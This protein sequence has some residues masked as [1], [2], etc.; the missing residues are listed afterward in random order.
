MS[1]KFHEP[2]LGLRGKDVLRRA[3]VHVPKS[4]SDK[5]SLPL[6]LSF[7]G[8]FGTAEMQMKASEMNDLSDKEE[9]LLVYP[10]GILR[11]WNSFIDTAAAQRTVHDV[12]FIDALLNLLILKF[13]ADPSRIY[14]VG[15]SNGGHIT[16]TLADAIGERLAAI[17][18]VASGIRTGADYR[19]THRLPLMIIHG[20]DDEYIPYNGGKGRRRED[21]YMPTEEFVRYAVKLNNAQP[22]ALAYSSYADFRPNSEVELSRYDGGRNGADVIFIKVN[23]GGH[24]W[25]SGSYSWFLGKT[26]QAISANEA[27]WEFFRTHAKKD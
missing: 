15:I 25:P 26:S 17:A 5:K 20:T 12:E 10:D 1:I 19:D 4:F 24:T 2:G 13:Q 8:G 3:L 23:G 21:V 9:V 14:S 7:H 6:I 11:S 27:I 18:L 22:K 16:L